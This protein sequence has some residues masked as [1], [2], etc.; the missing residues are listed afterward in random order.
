MKYSSFKKIS[1]VQRYAFKA[2]YGRGFWTICFGMFVGGALIVQIE[3]R[4]VS[5]TVEAIRNA[6]VE[7]TL[8]KHLV[9]I[10]ASK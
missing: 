8:S 1:L 2:G 4:A 9:R 3:N 5:P 6:A 7:T 10:P